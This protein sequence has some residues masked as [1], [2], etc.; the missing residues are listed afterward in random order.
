M[1]YIKG[2]GTYFL[3]MPYPSLFE[4]QMDPLPPAS[5]RAVVRC[6]ENPGAAIRGTTDIEREPRSGGSPAGWADT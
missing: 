1:T 3:P 5:I 4:R 6:N 2:H